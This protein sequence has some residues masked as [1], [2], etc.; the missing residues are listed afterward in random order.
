MEFICVVDLRERIRS[1][2]PST[3]GEIT[4]G[5]N[6]CGEVETPEAQRDEVNCSRR[7]VGDTHRE[8]VD[9]G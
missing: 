1:E 5:E 2:N 7:S 8:I 6:E 3:L 4:S 9:F